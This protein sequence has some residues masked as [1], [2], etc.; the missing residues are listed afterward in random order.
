MLF[1]FGWVGVNSS[2]KDEG[3]SR[4]EKMNVLPPSRP[5]VRVQHAVLENLF[6]PSTLGTKISSTLA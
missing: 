5:E 3:F 6:V 4:G 2:C 1:L